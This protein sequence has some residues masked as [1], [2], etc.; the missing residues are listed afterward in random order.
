MYYSLRALASDLASPG[1]GVYLHVII[2][3]DGTVRFYA[4]QAVCLRTRIREHSSSVYRD[5]YPSL[6][7]S[8]LASAVDDFFVTLGS[9]S[10]CGELNEGQVLN[11]LEMWAS[12]IFRTLPPHK[13]EEF[14]PPGIPVTFDGYYGLNVGLPLAQGDSR[15]GK[16][17]HDLSKTRDPLAMAY[18]L[19]RLRDAQVVSTAVKNDKLRTRLLSGDIFKCTPMKNTK[20]RPSGRVYFRGVAIIIP[21]D[22]DVKTVFVRCAQAHPEMCCEAQPQDPARRLAVRVE[23]DSVDDGRKHA[24]WYSQKG[25]ANTQKINSLVDYLEGRDEEYTE[26]QPRRFLDRNKTRGRTSI[27]YTSDSPSESPPAAKR[28]KLTHDEDED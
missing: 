17:L 2:D 9:L 27:S 13:M 20:G 14:L 11:I 10:G 22:A 23:Y 25:D 6:H 21:P 16:S 15:A 1:A 3:A 24:F 26:N 7:Y 8:A 18:Y 5:K 28:R 12:L 4:G 19:R